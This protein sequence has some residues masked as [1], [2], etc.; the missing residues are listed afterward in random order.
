MM[1]R[2]SLNTV[3]LLAAFEVLYGHTVAH[4]EITSLPSWLDSI[5]RFFSGVPIFFTMSGFLIWMSIARSTTFGQYCKKRFWRIFPELWVAVAVEI[6]ALLLLYDHAIEWGKLSLF[7]VTQSTIFQFWTPDFLR[8]YGCGCPNGSLWTICVLI[9]FY[10]IAFYVY[11]WLRGKNLKIWI[12]ALVLSIGISA[13]TPV[14]QDCVPEIISKFYGQTFI[15]YFWMFIFG[16]M[17]SEFGKGK[18]L[19]VIKKYWWAAF[20][21][22]VLI[23]VSGFD[24]RLVHY[25]LFRTML[26]FVCL[27]G[28]AYAVPQVNIKTDI[29]YAVYI[30]HMTVVNAMITLGYLQKPIYLLL[31]TILTFGISYM[32]TKLVGNWSQKM[33]KMISSP[34]SQLINA[35]V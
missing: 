17:V 18:W 2:N 5:I 12:L 28:F 33:K 30:Y 13:I 34:N 23:I 25:G 3:R 6:I 26:L 15:P 21:V 31:V 20:L 24:L 16:A 11:K 9:Q 7:A 29:S 14:I 27:L 35:K 8:E 10:V 1:E 4:L 19:P 32:S 22:T